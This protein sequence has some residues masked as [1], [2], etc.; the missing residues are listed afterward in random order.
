[1]TLKLLDIIGEHELEKITEADAL[2]LRSILNGSKKTDRLYF[3]DPVVDHMIVHN[4][5]KV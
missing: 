5:N 4:W 1:M 2:W 3:T